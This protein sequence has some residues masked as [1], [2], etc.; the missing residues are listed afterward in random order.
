[1]ALTIFAAGVA[2]VN[3]VLSL[4]PKTPLTI[5]EI[6]HLADM[7]YI[8]AKSA[9]G[10]LVKRGISLNGAVVYEPVENGIAS[11]VAYQA[12]LVD[13]PW[14]DALKSV[15]LGYPAVAAIFVHGSAARGEMRRDSD[16]DILV[17]GATTA[18]ILDGAMDEIRRI[19]GREIDIACYTQ[20]EVLSGAKRAAPVAAI[21]SR[22]V[23]VFGEWS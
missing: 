13:L 19:A 9:L 1:M 3:C 20:D 2:R 16:I 14:E 6:S 4:N 5:A 18:A 22:A 8:Q 7:Q 10:T 17:I 23:R 21:L 12:S 15:G 11:R